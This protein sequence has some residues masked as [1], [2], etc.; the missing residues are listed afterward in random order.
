MDQLELIFMIS[1]R[2]PG[3]LKVKDQKNMQT[4]DL[5]ELT[6]AGFLSLKLE[7]AG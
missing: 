1:I 5:Y 2:F 6:P 7:E 3:H 4:Y